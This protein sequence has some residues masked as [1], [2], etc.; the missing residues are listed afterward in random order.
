MPLRVNKNINIQR[1]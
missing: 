1:R